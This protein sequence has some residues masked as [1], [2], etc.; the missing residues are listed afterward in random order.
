MII[1]ILLINLYFISVSTYEF[2][3]KNKK[4]FYY[5]K[6][7]Q[8]E[9]TVFN[10]PSIRS[11]GLA[12]INLI[13]FLFGLIFLEKFKN[14]YSIFFI[15]V[16]LFIIFLLQSRVNIYSAWF[17]L[18]FFLIFFKN[19]KIKE[20]VKLFAIFLK[21][22]KNNMIIHVNKIGVNGYISV[23]GDFIDN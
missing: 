20:R 12:R 17:F 22:P 18:I 6:I 19:F 5:L 2:F 3:L 7:F 8:I 21:L 9:T 15:I 23:S 14:I 13:L 16:N 1:L 4:P 11:T 10:S